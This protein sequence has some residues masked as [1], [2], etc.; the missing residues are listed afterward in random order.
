MPSFAPILGAICALLLALA[1]GLST[2]AAPLVALVALVAQAAPS[3]PRPTP[4][5][6]V[7]DLPD[8]SLLFHLL[9][10]CEV[11]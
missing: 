7:I 2:P 5:G 9:T 3:A 8:A 11:I 10:N 1:L 6:P 4:P